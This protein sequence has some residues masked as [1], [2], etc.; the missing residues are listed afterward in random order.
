MSAVT[1][2]ATDTTHVPP[3]GT[4]V[5]D[6]SH[7]SVNFSARHLGLSKVR[8]HFAEFEGTIEVGEDPLDSSVQV[9]IHTHS[10]GTGTPQRDDHLRSPDFLDVAN[11]PTMDFVSRSVER[12]GDGYR[13]TGDLT[14]RGVTRPVT[15]DVEFLGVIPDPMSG[16]R[17]MSFEARTEINRED[18]GLTWN[19]PLETGQI[20]VGKKVT[21]ELGVSAT[22]A[23]AE[24]AD[25][26]REEAS[27]ASV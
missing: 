8:G 17:R 4:W 23:P 1:D 25:E 18:F 15:L 11:H 6:P 21:I 20:L 19:A 5:I 7:S 2:T 16:G 27:S 24:S 22:S 9:A 12:V 10:V 14:I 3:P 26:V 13:L